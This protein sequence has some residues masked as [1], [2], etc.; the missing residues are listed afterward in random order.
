[1]SYAA[2]IHCTESWVARMFSPC[3]IEPGGLIRHSVSEVED[4][5]GRRRLEA[6][7]RERGYRLVEA[8]E[9]FII[10]CDRP[11]LRIIV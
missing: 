4:K 3:S 11:P 8:G 1:M 5:I 6:E 2:S 7:V 10:L 9:H